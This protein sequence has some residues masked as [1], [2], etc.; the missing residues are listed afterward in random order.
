[1]KRVIVSLIYVDLKSCS[2]SYAFWSDGVLEK[3]IIKGCVGVIYK[4]LKF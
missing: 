1:M 3:L 2:M 4:E